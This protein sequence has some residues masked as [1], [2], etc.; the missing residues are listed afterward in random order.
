MTIT[1]RYA[2]TCRT[3]GGRIAAG[4]AIDW[5]RDSGAAH[6]TC[7]A[8]TQRTTKSCVRCGETSNLMVASLGYACP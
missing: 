6:V 5:T 7:P 4:T 8:Q 2:G 1:A 3:C